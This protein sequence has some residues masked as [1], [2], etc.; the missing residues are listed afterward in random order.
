MGKF[1]VRDLAYLIMSIPYEAC[2]TLIITSWFSVRF[3]PHASS[4]NIIAEPLID[5]SL[6]DFIKRTL[7]MRP[8]IP[9]PT[10]LLRHC[11]RTHLPSATAIRPSLLQIRGKADTQLPS[12]SMTSSSFD[13]PFK[14]MRDETPTTQ[15]PRF[16]KYKSK[17]SREHN[18]VFQYFMVGTMGLLAAAGAKGTVQSFLVN[19][20]A[21]ADVLAQA[22][23][24]V[25][26]AAIPIGKNVRH[27]SPDLFNPPL[28][29]A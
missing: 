15:I 6:S 14:N 26:L 13:S 9:A 25:D 16:D 21:S 2:P 19:M 18:L 29:R 3:V 4:P 24:E 17:R 23:V 22:K 7:K 12:D 5:P 27:L 11:A 10:A 1:K 20:S 28:P 8:L